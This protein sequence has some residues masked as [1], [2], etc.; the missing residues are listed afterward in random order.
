LFNR[1]EPQQL[2]D[3]DLPP[4]QPWDTRAFAMQSVPLAPFPPG[5]YELE[6]TVTDRVTRATAR[7]TVAFTVASGVR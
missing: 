2:S 7:S 4:P 6:V 5:P 1:T 3:A